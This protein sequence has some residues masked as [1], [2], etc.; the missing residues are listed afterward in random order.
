M[1]VMFDPLANLSL[2]SFFV[3]TI[4]VHDQATRYFFQVELVSLWGAIISHRERNK[5]NPRVDKG[6][7]SRINTEDIILKLDV[8]IDPTL[9]FLHMTSIEKHMDE[10]EGI[11]FLSDL[12]F[13]H[14]Q[15]D[16]Q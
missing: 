1:L 16:R 11:S 9:R 6:P 8:D 14:R 13:Y 15:T 2:I 4:P 12:H 10:C 7:I 5:G 3:R